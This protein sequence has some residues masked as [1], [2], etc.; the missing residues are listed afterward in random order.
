MYQILDLLAMLD[1]MKIAQQMQ[2]ISQHLTQEAEAARRRVII[3]NQLMDRARNHQDDLLE[4][5]ERWCDRI[6][7]AVAQPIEPLDTRISLQ[8]APEAHTVL[9]TD[10]SQIAPSH[11]EIAY[12]YLL[13]IGRIVL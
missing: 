6:G 7:F 4:Q 10:G 3:A 1:L 5:W 11:H 9:A 2:G 12:C 8:A 13:N